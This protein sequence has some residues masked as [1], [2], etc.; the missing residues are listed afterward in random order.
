[1]ICSGCNGSGAC[2]PCDGYGTF[3]DSYPNAGDGD[4]CTTCG[5]DGLCVD[6][7]DTTTNETDNNDSVKAS[8]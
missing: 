3:P 5:G 2:D 6:C 4:E 1:M 8:A 7:H